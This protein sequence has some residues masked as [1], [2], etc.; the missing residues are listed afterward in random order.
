MALLDF[1]PAALPRLLDVCPPYVRRLV[2]ESVA[3]AT[4]PEYVCDEPPPRTLNLV[5]S[6]AL[7]GIYHNLTSHLTY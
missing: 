4:I 6:A 7:A 1:A 5:S 3:P 2:E